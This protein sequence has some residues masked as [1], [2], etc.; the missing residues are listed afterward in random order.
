MEAVASLRNVYRTTWHHSSWSL[1]W[2]YRTSLVLIPSCIAQHA[3]EQWCTCLIPWE[4]SNLYMHGPMVV[5]ALQTCN[6]ISDIIPGSS[7]ERVITSI[8][9][10]L[11]QRRQYFPTVY[12]W[13]AKSNILLLMIGRVDR[14]WRNFISM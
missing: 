1:P 14:H 5:H 10:H 4:D 7:H 6:Y 8:V 13:S 2:R 3:M 11:W 9:P 12:G